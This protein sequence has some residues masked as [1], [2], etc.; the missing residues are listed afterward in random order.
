MRGEQARDRLHGQGQRDVIYG[1][2]E[3]D[4]ISGG[5][6]SDVIGGGPGNDLIRTRDGSVDVIDCGRGRKDRAEV[7][8]GDR[9][10]GCEIVKRS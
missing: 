9:V 2:G 3:A 5:K 7:G 8:P 4:V 10:S 1:N 6:G